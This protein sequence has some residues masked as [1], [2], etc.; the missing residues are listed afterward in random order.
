MR[1]PTETH[2]QD[3]MTREIIGVCPTTSVAALVQIFLRHEISGA[4]VVEEDGRAVGIVTVSDLLDPRRRTDATGVPRYVR[5]WAGD[6]RAVGIEDEGD[7]AGSGVVGDI[8]SR[9]L[10]TVDRH[11]TVRDA[12]RLMARADVH[13]LVVTDHGRPIG[14]VTTMDCLRA[15]AAD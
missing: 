6:V 13:R 8:M 15:L 12:A 2:V 14:L 5:L 9:E 4:P 7:V 3:V 11:A 1:S 10:V